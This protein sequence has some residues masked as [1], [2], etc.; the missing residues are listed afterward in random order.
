MGEGVAS[1]HTGLK[2]DV[3]DRNID[4]GVLPAALVSETELY[5]IGDA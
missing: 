2:L 1:D 3:H 5:M 4:A